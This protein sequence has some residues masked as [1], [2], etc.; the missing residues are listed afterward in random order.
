[1]PKVMANTHVFHFHSSMATSSFSSTE[2]YFFYSLRPDLDDS[3][4]AQLSFCENPL[5]SS[6]LLKRGPQIKIHL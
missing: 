3:A 2:L 5:A 4:H 1:M 6:I